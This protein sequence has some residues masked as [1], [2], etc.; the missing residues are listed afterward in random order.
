MISEKLL[1]KAGY[2]PIETALDSEVKSNA[3]LYGIGGLYS[4]RK[5]ASEHAKKLRRRGFLVRIQNKGAYYRL[6][7]RRGRR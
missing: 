2:R 5:D 4:Y 1:R 7:I 3:D 6:W